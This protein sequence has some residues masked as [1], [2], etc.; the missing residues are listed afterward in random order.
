MSYA[1]CDHLKEDGVY[2][3]HPP[4]LD[5]AHTLLAAS[6]SFKRRLSPPNFARKSLQLN[7]LPVTPLHRILCA[8]IVAY[9]HENKEPMG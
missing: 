5:P 8:R 6:R 1:T 9:L 2:N 4:P 7:H 3:I